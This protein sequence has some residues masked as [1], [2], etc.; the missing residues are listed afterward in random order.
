MT[1]SYMDRDYGRITI[2]VLKAYKSRQAELADPYAK[3]MTLLSYVDSSGN[4]C[5]TACDTYCRLVVL[6]FEAQHILNRRLIAEEAASIKKPT[7]WVSS[8]EL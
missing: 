3:W 8:L 5:S 7:L 4:V 6:D 2:K 1:C